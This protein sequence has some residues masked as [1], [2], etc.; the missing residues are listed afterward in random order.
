MRVDLPS[1]RLMYPGLIAAALLATLAVYWIGLRGA[2]MFDDAPVFSG[3]KLWLA[4]DLGLREV[5]FNNNSWLTHRA[6]A[7]A[8][9]ATSAALFGY[10][11][12]GFKLFNLVLHL[13]CGVLV[14]VVLERGLRRDVQLRA[15]SRLVALLVAA[16]WL[17][18]PLHVSTVLYA[19]QQMAQ[20]AA[21]CCLLG[22]WLYI[23]VRERMEAG[24][25]PNGGLLLLVAISALTLLGIQGKQ[26]AAIL[27][28]LCL[29]VELAWFRGPREWPRVLTGFYTL[30]LL[31]PGAL[32]ALVLVARPDAIFN[33]FAE[34]T[35]TPLERLLSQGRVLCDY[36][37]MLLVPHSPSM[38]VYTDD[39]VP[40]TGL[41]SPASTLPAILLLLGLSIMAWR[42]RRKMPA[43]FAGWFLFLAGHVVEGSILPIELYYEHRNYLPA[44]GLFLA[45]ASVIA[46]AGR[47]L[48]GRGVRAGRVGLVCG[49]AL[50]AVLALQ[51]HGRARVWSDPLVLAESAVKEHPDS[52]RAVTNYIGI[53]HDLGDFERAYAMADATIAGSVSA[54]TRGQVTLFRMWLDCQTKGTAD[55]ADFAAAMDL[56]PT[57]IDLQTF[58]LFGF[59]RQ[60]IETGTCGDIRTEFADMLVAL[61]ERATPQKA[62]DWPIWRT[63]FLA[64]RT[65]ANSGDWDKAL[66]YARRSWQPQA[67]SPV[68][69]LLI[70]A[71]LHH[72]LVAEAEGVVAQAAARAKGMAD[73]EG[74]EQLR[75]MVLQEKNGPGAARRANDENVIPDSS[76]AAGSGDATVRDA[77]FPAQEINQ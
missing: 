22:L 2:F 55:P 42:V 52:V 64:G 66:E 12:F 6:L 18:H 72:Q 13:I 23:A 4:G 16:V 58:M 7:M 27:P 63:Y 30:L 26:N 40:S 3:I 20:W 25:A 1:S 75:Q 15:Q 56:L 34:Y 29:V 21:L 59:L 46:A 41:M 73:D 35:F 39:Y 14:Y 62:T 76:G 50:L 77:K 11:P 49:A 10:D 33:G 47:W 45:C 70:K 17:L 31:V 28:A 19:V 36:L 60:N 57:H 53:A 54:R 69:E 48:S 24:R 9:F 32:L 8:S 51:T 5:L 65:Y 61:A 67:P 44:A 71:L 74:V 68:A 38:G 43:L 37:Q